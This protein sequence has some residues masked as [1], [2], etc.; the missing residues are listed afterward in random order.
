MDG[1]N[2]GE[3]CFSSLYFPI[4]FVEFPK[5]LL[6]FY[7]LPLSLFTA[8]ALVQ[9]TIISHLD[10]FNSPRGLSVSLLV[11]VLPSHH[12]A[13]SVLF[14]KLALLH[15]SFKVSRCSILLLEWPFAMAG[16]A[17]LRWLGHSHTGLRSAAQTPV[18]LP[19]ELL[20]RW[21]PLAETLSA[22]PQ[23]LGTAG[24]YSPFRFLF[25]GHLLRTPSLN[26]FLKVASFPS[27]TRKYVT[28]LCGL[29]ST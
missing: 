24:S 6:Q 20:E 19:R 23:R 12:T 7:V 3:L 18:L 14:S 11:L 22:F 29:H 17:D 5:S 8:P 10:Y 9:I 1:E 2:Y 28:L 4:F 26:N 13:A 16:K 21:F 25:E 15:V 27:S